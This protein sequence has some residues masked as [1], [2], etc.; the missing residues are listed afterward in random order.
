MFPE[1]GIDRD[2]SLT[3]SFPTEYTENSDKVCLYSKYILL[4]LT[5]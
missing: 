3:L 4:F 2:D 1:I 5:M